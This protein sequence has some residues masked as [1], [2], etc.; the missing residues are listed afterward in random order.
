ML[1][2]FQTF[3]LKMA[4]HQ[5]LSHDLG[6]GLEAWG[7]GRGRAEDLSSGPYPLLTGS[8]HPWPHTVS[9]YPQRLHRGAASRVRVIIP[10]PGQIHRSGGNHW[11]QVF[12]AICLMS[13]ISFVHYA[14]FTLA[15]VGAL[16]PS[17]RDVPIFV[18]A[19]SLVRSSPNSP[20]LLSQGQ[21]PVSEPPTL[22]LLKSLDSLPI[23]RVLFR[24]RNRSS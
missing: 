8:F 4:I 11:S 20:F 6:E 18:T 12:F 5:D 14:I 2:S 21:T 15:K 1:F 7:E 23:I 17:F 10:Q 16:L 24:L 19:C 9:S 3:A 13:H 22:I